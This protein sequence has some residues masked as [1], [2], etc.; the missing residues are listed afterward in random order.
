[1]KNLQII[2]LAVDIAMMTCAVSVS[3]HLEGS[4]IMYSNIIH[5]TER[6]G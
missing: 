5:L 2:G 6:C 3:I 1:M 4:H